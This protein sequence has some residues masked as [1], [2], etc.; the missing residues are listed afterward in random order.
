MGYDGY[1]AGIDAPLLFRAVRDIEKKS[2]T[3]AF[4]CSIQAKEVGAKRNYVCI[5]GCCDWRLPQSVDLYSILCCSG[6]ISSLD[7]EGGDRK[8]LSEIDSPLLCQ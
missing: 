3:K 2:R 8:G 5:Q 7:Q 6:Q 4:V 1:D